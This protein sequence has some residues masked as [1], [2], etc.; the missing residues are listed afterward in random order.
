MDKHFYKKKQDYSDVE[1][2]LNALQNNIVNGVAYDDPILKYFIK[3]HSDFSDLEILP[4]KYN[5]QYYALGFTF[6]LD[7]DLRR[8]ISKKIIEISEES[9]WNLL[10]AEY[11]LSEL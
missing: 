3:N 4:I 2:C 6:S 7:K 8:K 10:L 9:D 11:N 1:K 5:A